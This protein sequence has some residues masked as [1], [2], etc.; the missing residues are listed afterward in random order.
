[1]T[2]RRTAIFIVLSL[3]FAGVATYAVALAQWGDCS[4]SSTTCE[5]DRVRDGHVMLAVCVG[6][7]LLGT[8]LLLK[9]W[10]EF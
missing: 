1:M 4:P 2:V 5:A 3:L 8:L 10:K 6:F 7:Y 9:R